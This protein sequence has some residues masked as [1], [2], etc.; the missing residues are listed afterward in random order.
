ML[1]GGAP[2]PELSRFDLLLMPVLLEARRYGIG[3]DWRL[4]KLLRT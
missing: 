4:K 3:V 2:N 1:M